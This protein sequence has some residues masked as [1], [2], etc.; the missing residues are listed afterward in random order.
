MKVDIWSDVMCPFCYIGKRHF[1]QALQ[2]LTYGDSI[3]VVWHSFQLDP[4]TKTQPDKD[5]YSYLAERKGQTLEW[6]KQAHKHVSDMAARA[7]LQY[8]FD[9]AVVANSFDAHRV[10]QLAK[11][12]G[13]GDAMEEQLFKGYFTEGKNI[14]DHDVLADMAAG[15]GIEKQAVSDVLNSD[16]YSA[17]VKADIETAARIGINGVPFFVINNRYGVSGAQPAATFVEALNK[18]WEEYAKE[19]SGITM[20]DGEAASCETGGEC[21]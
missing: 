21:K 19:K 13:K 3:E 18:A 14:A 4:D 16:A 17:E 20:V 12:Y 10:V 8:N 5:V 9:K 11:T 1:E 15:I 2:Q 6:S 7:G